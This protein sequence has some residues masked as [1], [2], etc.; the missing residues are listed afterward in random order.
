MKIRKIL[1]WAGGGIAVLFVLGFVLSLNNT[2]TPVEVAPVTNPKPSEIKTVSPEL[3]G[4][5]ITQLLGLTNEDRSVVGVHPLVLS[6]VLDSSA[7]DKCNDMVTNDYW[8]HNSPSGLTP[9]VFINRYTTFNKAGENLAFN[10]GSSQ[11]VET[12][13]MNSPEHKVNILDP[14]FNDVGFG[15]CKSSNLQGMGAGLIV[16][17]HFTD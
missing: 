5:D 12:G 4:I 8:A 3:S 10:F 13:W 1:K 2:N 14:V 17:E 15:V 11:A 6:A 16:V 9:W 7:T